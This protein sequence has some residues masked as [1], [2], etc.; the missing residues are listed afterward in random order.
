MFEKSELSKKL[1]SEL[2]EIAN[3]AGITGTEKLKKQDLVEKIIAKKTTET[4]KTESKTLAPVTATDKK[5]RK[6]ILKPTADSL[7]KNP[8]GEKK[9]RYSSN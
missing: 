9:S 1:V 3:T 6:R 5:P 8:A 2:R 7:F 4:L